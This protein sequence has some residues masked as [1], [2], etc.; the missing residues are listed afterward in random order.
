LAQVAPNS[1]QRNLPTPQHPY[2]FA[3]LSGETIDALMKVDFEHARNVQANVAADRRRPDSSV[4]RECRA[5]FKIWESAQ[6]RP[7]TTVSIRTVKAD[8]AQRE[9]MASLYLG[10][11]ESFQKALPISEKLLA[12]KEMAQDP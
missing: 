4:P 12:S 9:L 8:A 1:T 7:L 5:I 10:Q 2:V 3:E 11:P 6:I